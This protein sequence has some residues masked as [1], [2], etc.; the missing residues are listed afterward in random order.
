MDVFVDQHLHRV[1]GLRLVRFP[2]NPFL[3][4][5]SALPF[6]L[7][8]A[9][10]SDCPRALSLLLYPDLKGSNIAFIP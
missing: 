10:R 9:S 3:D 7:T 5:W 1:R 6:P 4:A 8:Q 2:I